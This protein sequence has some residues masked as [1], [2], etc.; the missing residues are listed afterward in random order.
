MTTI[1]KGTLLKLEGHPEKVLNC[2][3]PAATPPY[4]GK[5]TENHMTCKF[6][7]S[8]SFGDQ[9]PRNRWQQQEWIIF[10]QTAS[11]A[12]IFRHLTKL[13]S[14]ESLKDDIMGFKRRTQL[15]Q[16]TLEEPAKRIQN[17]TH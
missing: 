6:L 13:L 1:L 4:P 12:L 11:K 15:G 5:M 10:C 2:Q 3:I 17:Q 8:T 7:P 16:Q 14:E 9:K